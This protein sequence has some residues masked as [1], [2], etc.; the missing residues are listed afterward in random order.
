MECAE[1]IISY[2]FLRFATLRIVPLDQRHFD[3]LV[4]DELAE[5]DGCAVQTV[6]PGFMDERRG[7][8]NLRAPHDGLSGPTEAWP[9]AEDR[10]PK[11]S[12]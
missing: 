2:I 11:K 7:K 4:P 6:T 10:P 12:A 8:G 1:E 9:L 5:R 3:P